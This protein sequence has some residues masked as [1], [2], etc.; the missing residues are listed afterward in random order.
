MTRSDVRINSLTLRDGK[1]NQRRCSDSGESSVISSCYR[2]LTYDVIK[3]I[4]DWRDCDVCSR[5]IQVGTGGDS[6]WAN[7]IDSKGHKQ[8]LKKLRDKSKSKSLT[9]FFKPVPR[10]DYSVPSP[11]STSESYTEERPENQARKLV[12]LQVPIDCDV[13][14][15]V[16]TIG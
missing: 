11:V 16:C 8:N 9:A 14:A 7:H 1:E 13:L 15:L 10:P 6:N 2:F 3:S 4:D 12:S 5:P